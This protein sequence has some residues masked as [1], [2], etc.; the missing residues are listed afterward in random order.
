[1]TEGSAREKKYETHTQDHDDVARDE[2]GEEEVKGKL[3]TRRV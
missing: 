2:V 1:V 3:T